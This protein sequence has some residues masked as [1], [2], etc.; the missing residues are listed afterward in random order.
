M[1]KGRK[2]VKLWDVI[3]LEYGK[4]LP[5]RD[6]IPGNYNVYGSWWI[7][8]SHQNYIEKWPW[9]IVW[10]KGTIWSVYRS[11]ENFFPIDTVFYVKLRKDDD[12]KFIYYLLWVIWLD[13]LNSDAA[14]PWLNRNVAYL[15]DI[16]LPSLC[17]QQ[18]IASILTKYDDLIEN[19]NQRIK[20]LEQEAELIYKEW[21]VKFKFPWHEDVKMVDSWTEFGMIPES[22]EV[23]KL[24]DIIKKTKNTYIE[25][26]H[27]NLP[28]LDLSRIPRKSLALSN[29]WKSDEITTSRIVAKTYDIMFWAIRPYFHK[30]I[31]SMEDCITN[32]S[33]FV[34]NVYD[35]KHYYFIFN[36]LFDTNTVN[37][38][39]KNSWWTKMPVIW[40]EVFTNMNIILSSNDVLVKFNT[41]MQNFF[42]EIILL[43]KQNKSL[44]KTRDMLLPKLI[45]GEIEI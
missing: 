4:W 33:V 39:T 22:W 26:K 43:N 38:A 14:V 10:R 20:I 6:R 7:V 19:N 25:N 40:R 8:D 28:L 35:K 12:L 3:I 31:F 29:Y 24:W 23:K 30:V 13:K 5:Q 17:T 27:N 41:L 18:K 36:L 34:M 32:T 11:K 9:I 2:K 15:Q 1:N 42:D 45:N 21:F 16:S 44:R 37:R